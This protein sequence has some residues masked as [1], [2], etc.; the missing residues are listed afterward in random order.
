M[1]WGKICRIGGKSFRDT[2]NS[3]GQLAPRGEIR[4]VKFAA[5]AENPLLMN[6]C[7]AAAQA[8]PAAFRGAKRPVEQNAR[9]T[10]Q[11]GG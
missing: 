9:G 1:L 7:C 6:P 8:L 2:V 10:S 3:A 5:N 11:N 4:P